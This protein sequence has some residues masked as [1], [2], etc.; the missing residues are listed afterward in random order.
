MPT[1]VF[2]VMVSINSDDIRMAAIVAVVVAVLMAVVRLMGG[3][4]VRYVASGVVGVALAAFV[5][6]RTGRA[7]NFFLP[8]LLLNIGWSAVFIGSILARRPLV[9]YLAASLTG[10]KDTLGDWRKDPA[11]RIPAARATWVF[12]GVFV[13]RL[14]VQVPLYL[15]NSLVALGTA[16]LAMGVPL[17]AVGVWLSWL[18]MRPSPFLAGRR[19]PSPQA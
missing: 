11:C 8:G 14:V 19:K 9:G 4:T 3:Q 17:V 7:E 2:I 15:S 18:L 10:A 13:A 5:A 6:A 1:I 12:V 16:K